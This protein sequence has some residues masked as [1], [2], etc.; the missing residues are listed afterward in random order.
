MLVLVDGCLSTKTSVRREPEGAVTWALA[1]K[2]VISTDAAYR[3]EIRAA[4]S[5]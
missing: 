5:G 3:L 4:G 2:A 1:I